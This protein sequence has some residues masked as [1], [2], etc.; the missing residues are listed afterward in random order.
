MPHQGDHR[1][2]P[3]RGDSRSNTPRRSESPRRRDNQRS[4]SRS[5]QRPAA[6]QGPPNFQTQIYVAGISRNVTADD[7]RQPFEKFGDVREVIMKGRYAFIDF[8]DVKDAQTAVQ[9]L[10][11]T[12]FAGNTLIVEN[13]KKNGGGPR[14]GGRATGPQDKDEC[15]RCGEFGHWANECGRRGGDRR[16]GHDRRDNYRRRSN[17]RD[18][19]RSPPP[20]YRQRRS[21]RSD[22]RENERREGRCFG[23]KQR[24]HIKAHCPERGGDRRG[25]MRGDRYGDRRRDDRMGGYG[26]DG[27][28]RRYHS[29]SRSPPRDRRG[30]RDYQD[31]SPPRDRRDY[32]PRSRSPPRRYDRNDSRSPAYNHM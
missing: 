25:D 6:D 21:S 1:S 29:R 19:R 3:P 20:H 2:P 5:P 31:R 30:H 8:K 22:S 23:C 10:H 14:E 13:T 4:P 28:S 9:E 7:L 27:P 24:G 26:R 16:G 12:H 11:M 18:R 15:W 17:S 32:S